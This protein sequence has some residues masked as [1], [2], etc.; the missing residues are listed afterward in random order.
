MRCKTKQ[1]EDSRSVDPRV[2]SHHDSA[3]AG[4]GGSSREGW[5]EINDHR[6]RESVRGRQNS[7]YRHRNEGRFR[8]RRRPSPFFSKIAGVEL[9]V[10]LP[11]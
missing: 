3:F 7:A 8:K 6:G 11:G 2:S 4:S 10:A 9:T 5:I 1:R